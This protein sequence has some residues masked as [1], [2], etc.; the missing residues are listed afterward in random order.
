[1]KFNLVIDQEKE[2][3]VTVVC[4]RVTPIVEKIQ[5]LCE[6]F[7][8]TEQLLYGYTEEEVVP[9]ELANVT[10]FYTKNSKVFAYVGEQSYAIKLRLKQVLEMVDDSFIKVNQGCIANVAHIQKFGVSF[11]G[12]LK[13]VFKNGYS[14]YVARREVANIKR[15]FGL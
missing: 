3:S 12:A 9:L 14:D 10:C 8:E 2:P 7:A 13:V 11:G 15:R 6:E 4:N 5:Q 1:M